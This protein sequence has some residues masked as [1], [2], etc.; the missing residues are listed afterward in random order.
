M[1]HLFHVGELASTRADGPLAARPGEARAVVGPGGIQIVVALGEPGQAERDA[2]EVGAVSLGVADEPDSTG[3]GHPAGGGRTA[4]LV[5]V[6]EPG[7]PGH[8]EATAEVEVGVWWGGDV[9][10]ALCD[11]RGV[12][13]AVRRFQGP[14]VDPVAGSS[15]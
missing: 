3:D 8:L 9:E 14:T 7:E 15:R 6:G 1:T 10:L 4:L 2:V 12:V 11:A 13:R 5:R